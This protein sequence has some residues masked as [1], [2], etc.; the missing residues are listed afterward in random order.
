MHES[1]FADVDVSR[2]RPA[3]PT[4]WL[5][6]SDVGLK[7][8][9]ARIISAIHVVHFEKYITFVAIQR[10]QLT[11]TVVDNSHRRRKAKLAGTAAHNQGIVGIVDSSAN[12]AIDVY[13]KLGVFAEQL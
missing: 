2:P 9:E 3:S 13:V 1:I 10:A 6:I 7:P 5:A 12:H 4:V 11:V 8:V